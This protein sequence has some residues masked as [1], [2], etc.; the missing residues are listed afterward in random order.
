MCDKQQS[1]FVYYI[2]IVA[3]YECRPTMLAVSRIQVGF[4]D[5]VFSPSHT[6]FHTTLLKNCGMG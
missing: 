2:L 1:I 5:V 3:V 6:R 4:Q